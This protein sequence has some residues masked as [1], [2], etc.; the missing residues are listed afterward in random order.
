MI[1]HESRRKLVIPSQELGVK[2][3]EEFCDR[4]HPHPL[5]LPD[6]ENCYS[7]NNR[8]TAHERHTSTTQR[9]RK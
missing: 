8:S 3:S 6:V 5:I 2:S 7:Y 9:L 1:G 4:F